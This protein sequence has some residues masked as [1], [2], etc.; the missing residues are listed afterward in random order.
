MDGDPFRDPTEARS[1]PGT[2]LRL[3]DRSLEAKSEAR[4]ERYAQKCCPVAVHE[5]LDVREGLDHPPPRHQRAVER[6]VDPSEVDLAQAGNGTGAAVPPSADLASTLN[7]IQRARSR[8]VCF[9]EVFLRALRELSSRLP[10][11]PGSGSL[12]PLQD[13]AL[14]HVRN[15]GAHRKATLRCKRTETFGA[16][17]NQAE[18][19]VL[20]CT[21][22]SR[23]VGPDRPDLPLRAH[24]S[25]VRLAV[26]SRVAGPATLQDDASARV[27]SAAIPRLCHGASPSFRVSTDNYVGTLLHART[28]A[29]SSLASSKRSKRGHYV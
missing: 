19:C 6:G 18:P 26:A 27:S 7:W 16:S 9:R 3:P 14:E 17:R 23:P 1:Q 2:I 21:W 10:V 5:G 8:R 29:L 20:H 11:L 28:A 13:G 4:V 15:G 24:L 12:R 25:A 22:S